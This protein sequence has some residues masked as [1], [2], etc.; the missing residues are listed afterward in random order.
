MIPVSSD[1][2]CILCNVPFLFVT[3]VRLHLISKEHKEAVEKA[4]IK[5]PT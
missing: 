2:K 1:A 3:D 4:G 5:P